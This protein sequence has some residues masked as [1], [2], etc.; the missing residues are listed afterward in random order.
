[1]AGSLEAELRQTLPGKGS[2]D[3]VLQKKGNERTGQGKELSK[4]CGGGALELQPYRT[5]V[6]H[7][8]KETPLRLRATL[9]SW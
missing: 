6:P 8:G 7:G 4:Y 9:T 5:L 3:E 2:V 1:M